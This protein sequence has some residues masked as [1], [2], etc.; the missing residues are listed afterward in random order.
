M[1]DVNYLAVLVAAISAFILG[2]LWYSPMLFARSWMAESGVTMEMI[3]TDPTAARRY[4]I[5]FIAAVIAAYA[6]AV[7]LVRPD[8]HSLVI[9]IK[10]GFAGG[11]CWVAMSFASSY[12]FE[13]RSLRH[14]IINS[15]YYVVQFTVMGAVLG[16]MNRT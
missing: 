2:A 12:A 10:R 16:I 3:R 11:V 7:L 13:R 15:G 5:A 4:T 14:W 6:M 9:G 8:H 1:P